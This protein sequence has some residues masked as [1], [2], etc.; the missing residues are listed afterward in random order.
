VTVEANGRKAERFVMTILGETG[1]PSSRHGLSKTEEM[2]RTDF[3]INYCASVG[4]DGFGEFRNL[5]GADWSGLLEPHWRYQK[6]VRNAQSARK[7]QSIHRDRVNMGGLVPCVP[8]A[9]NC[10]FANLV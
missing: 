9:V 2:R 7:A 10:W 1:V 4:C 6:R 3:A 8:K 5:R